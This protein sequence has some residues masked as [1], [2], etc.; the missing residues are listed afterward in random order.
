M[1]YRKSNK[2]DDISMKRKR[3]A[4]YWLA[5]RD[6]LLQPPTE[7]IQTSG[8]PENTGIS[9]AATYLRIQKSKLYKMTSRRDFA[10]SRVGSQ[11]RFRK[12]ELDEFLENG[13]RQVTGSSTNEKAR[14]MLPTVHEKERK[15]KIDIEKPIRNYYIHLLYCYEVEE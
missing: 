9:E 5:A 14:F 11:L 15:L 12:R 8:D 1:E 6:Q 3:D 7:V 13:R 2:V 4:A 10:H